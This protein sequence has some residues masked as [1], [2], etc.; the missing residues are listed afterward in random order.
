MIRHQC[1]VCWQDAKLTKRGNIA[2]HNTVVREHCPGSGLA[3]TL[4]RYVEHG[5]AWEQIA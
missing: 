2:A 1:P 4:T 3:W 5:I